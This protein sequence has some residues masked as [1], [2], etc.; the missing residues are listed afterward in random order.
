[1]K[2]IARDGNN[3]F[4]RCKDQPEGIVNESKRNKMQE[5]Y[6]FNLRRSNQ[7]KLSNIKPNET[8][9]GAVRPA[10]VELYAETLFGCEDNKAIC[11]YSTTNSPNSFVQF[12]DNSETT[13]E[14]IHTQ[15][16][17]LNDGTYTYYVRCVD[18]G[19]NVANATT[20]FKVSIDT[21]APV[22]ARAYEEDGYLKLVTPL[23][24][25]C[26]Y[27]TESCDYLFN[28][29]TQMPYAN[30]TAHVTEWFADKKYFIKCRDQYRSEPVD[31]SLIVRPTDNFLGD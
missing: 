10:P 3:F 17:D 14:G 30:S 15:R 19:G 25:E 9:F 7:L 20:Q 8:I 4:V 21:N 13:N 23:N 5:S 11:Y 27:N 26:V 28:E 18:D 22:V 24:S 31:C 6:I 2:G 16:L 29:G 12:F 1:L